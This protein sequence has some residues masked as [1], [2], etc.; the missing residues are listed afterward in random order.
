LSHSNPAKNASGRPTKDAS[1]ASGDVVG[2]ET[3]ALPRDDAVLRHTHTHTHTQ[4]NCVLAE[5]THHHRQQQQPGKSSGW[6][7]EDL[8][9]EE[10]KHPEFLF[11]IAFLLV[12][13]WIPCT[14]VPSGAWPFACSKFSSQYS[15]V[16][17][18][19]SNE[20]CWSHL[21]VGATK[22]LSLSPNTH[23]HTCRHEKRGNNKP[24]EQQPPN[25][26]KPI[27]PDKATTTPS[28][29]HAQMTADE[30]ALTT[31][32]YRLAKELVRTFIR[33]LPTRII[34][35]LLLSGCPVCIFLSSLSLLPLSLCV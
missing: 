2:K 35:V 11:Y 22:A 13:R 8:K 6:N 9:G 3:S 29:H 25:G 10:K 18:N 33:I 21:G 16:I 26:G 20:P 24:S 19:G 28:K 30:A 31:K 17:D 12:V 14:T 15:F 27:S 23:T 34:D 32:N 7:D 1:K 5:S 4:P